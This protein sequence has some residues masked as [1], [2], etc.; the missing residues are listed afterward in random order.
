MLTFEGLATQTAEALRGGGVDAYGNTAERAVSNGSGV[1][2]RHCLRMVPKGTGYLIVA[3]RPFSGLQPYAETGPIFLC[4]GACAAPEDRRA[5]PEVL[6]ASP[7]YLLKGYG[8][9]ERIVYG[10][11]AIV[12]RD[13]VRAFA[14]E[15]L[16][17]ADIAFVDV[18]S[19]RNN[20]WLGRIHRLA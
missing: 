18:R 12:A 20:C 1:P 13:R 15:V 9:D 5:V 3:H 16:S 11:G 4:A 19:A 6:T 17:R 8:A 10:T 7:D 14:E 2:C